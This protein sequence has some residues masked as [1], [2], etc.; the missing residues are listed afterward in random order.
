LEDY[1]SLNKDCYIADYF[2]YQTGLR[3]FLDIAGDGFKDTKPFYYYNNY[4]HCKKFNYP[5]FQI[6]LDELQN[7]NKC[8]IFQNKINSVM[9]SYDKI[10]IWEDTENYIRE[11]SKKELEEF[12]HKNSLEELKIGS[13]NLGL[14]SK[15]HKNTLLATIS[16]GHKQSRR[17]YLKEYKV[18]NFTDTLSYYDF[19]KSSFTPLIEYFCENYKFNSIELELNNRY[20]NRFFEEH[21]NIYKSDIKFVKTNDVNPNYHYYKIKEWYV[22]NNEIPCLKSKTKS[23]ERFT[24]YHINKNYLKDKRNYK[25]LINIFSRSNRNSQ[26][27]WD[28]GYTKYEYIK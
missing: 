25:Y 11:I 1:T 17:K 16:I 9:V 23:V 12:H 7:K 19:K 20:F 10:Y 13:I 8:N 4:L 2:N 28:V 18:L 27:V 14:Y 15:Y 26:R 22:Y 5:Y 24:E 6:F 3:Y 21:N